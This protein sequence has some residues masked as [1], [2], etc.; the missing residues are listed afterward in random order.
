MD[1]QYFG[2][3]AVTITTKKARV[4]IDDNMLELGKKAIARD[5]DI[6][7]FTGAHGDVPG[8]RLLIGQPGEYEVAGISVYGFAARAHMDEEKTKTAT[9]Y[10]LLVDDTRI[11]VTG[12]VYP[13]LTEKQLEEIGV[14]DIMIVPVGGNGYTLDPTGAL[15][16]IK[17]VEPK[18]VIP[19]HYAD[20]ALNYPVPQQTLEQAL[21]ALSMEPA[22]TVDKLKLKGSD[23]SEG[24]M[25]LI[26]VNRS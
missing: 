25:K 21:Q 17:K 1:I 15:K 14:I 10:K 23:L 12:H 22:D 11:L 2:G 16:L 4:V 5:G 3:N 8:A 18:L 7:L 6:V 24:G 19:T 26:V 20:D 9:L 13:E